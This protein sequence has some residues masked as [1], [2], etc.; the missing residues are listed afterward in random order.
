M[1]STSTSLGICVALLAAAC[2]GGEP[3]DARGG[4]AGAAGVEGDFCD[5]VT[6]RVDS[7]TTAAAEGWSPPSER[8]GGTVVVSGSEEL[9]GMNALVSSDY[10]AAQFQQFVNL[11]TLVR[12]DE[13]LRPVPWLAERFE[14]ADDSMS[15]TFHLRDDVYW[16]DGVRTTADDV[17]FTFDRM[18][19]TAVAF[20]N[21]SFWDPYV[22]GPDGVEVT[23]AFTV[24][25]HLPLRAS[26]RPASGRVA[27]RAHHAEAPPRGRAGGPAGPAP[28]RRALSRGQRSVRVRGAP[29]G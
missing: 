28:V 21:R 23:D 18:T 13:E 10:T 15:I 16:H 20:P 3:D 5:V 12:Y 17:A 24:T 6:Q 8:Y 11:M 7:F 27:G 4:V 1:K 22:K 2:G 25:F 9:P 26:P 29:P 19:D 14:L